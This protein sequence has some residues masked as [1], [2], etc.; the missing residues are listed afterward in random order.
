MKFILVL[1]TLTASSLCFSLD[2]KDA[3]KS[4]RDI[5]N[6][7]SKASY[8]KNIEK[9]KDL[10]LKNFEIVFSKV[11]TED[12]ECVNKVGEEIDKKTCKQIRETLTNLIDL[13]ISMT[14]SISGL[15]PENI[16]VKHADKMKSTKEF[17]MAI[18]RLEECKKKAAYV[19]RLSKES[20]SRIY[21]EISKLSSSSTIGSEVMAYVEGAFPQYIPN[22]HHLGSYRAEDYKMYKQE[23][24]QN[25]SELKKRR[26][27][28]LIQNKKSPKKFKECKTFYDELNTKLGKVSSIR[29]NMILATKTR[30]KRAISEVNGELENFTYEVYNIEK[31]IDK[32]RCN[33][34]WFGN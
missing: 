17:D 16:N 18:A 32:S 34:F 22:N 25:K 23:F 27:L 24:L 3:N 19:K 20:Y 30:S 12:K 21:G 8:S 11:F 9:E 1:T 10:L 15:C 7:F 14:R 5:N 33:R 13:K 31:K 28:G 6:I 4:W 2:K 26:K 29:S